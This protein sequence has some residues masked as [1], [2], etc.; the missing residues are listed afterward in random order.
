MRADFDAA[1]VALCDAHIRAMMN[2]LMATTV[3]QIR[4]T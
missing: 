3:E 2:E 1:G 4:T